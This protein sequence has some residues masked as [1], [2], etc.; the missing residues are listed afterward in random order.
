MARKITKAPVW[1]PNDAAIEAVVDARHGDPFAILGMHAHPD[2]PVSVRVF[3]PGAD[4]AK[5][6]DKKT[7]R[8]VATLEKLHPAGFFAGPVPRRRSPFPYL[9]E[10][11][12]AAASWRTED[13]YRFPPILGDLDVHL[14]AEGRH[15]RVYDRLG[16]HPRRMEDVDGVAFAVWAP[17]ASRVS[18]V[19]E[20]NQWDG[21]RHPMRK[22][23]DIGVWE[24]FIPGVEPGATYKYEILGPDGRLQPLK[25][26]PIA[27][28][29]EHPP[30]TAS[31]IV[32]ADTHQ[33]RDD[34]WLAE[35]Q[36]RQGLAAPMSVYEVHLGSWRRKDGNAYLSYADLADQL[37]AYA[38]DI[39]FTHLEL[40]PVSEFPFDGSW[41][42]Q[43][44]GLFAPTS[45][46]GTP[47]DFAEF[48]D[49]CHEAGLGVI[50]D[51][52]PA[53]FPS[54]AH[55]LMRF[56]GTALYEHEDPRLG[57]HKDWN[58]LIYNFGRNE[59]RNFLIANAL[60]WLERFHI[61]ALR[62]D[63]VA[64][65]LYLDYSRNAGEWIP[66]V[67]GGREN[68]EAIGFIRELNTATFG[69]HPGTTTIAEESTSW[70]QVSRPVDGGGLGFGYKWNMGWM[71]DTL[72]YMSH[73]PVHRKHHHHQMTFG[74]HYAYSEN[75]VLPLSHDE[76]VHGKGSLIGKMP[77]DP[78][79][80]FA[81]L[82][83]YFGFMWTHPGKKLLFMG[84]E[85][86]QEREWNHDRSLDWHLLD[87]APHREV[88]SLVR[89]LNRIY[90]EIP[91]LHVKDADP[92][93]FEWV[94]ATDAAN[95]VYAYLRY[96]ND[97]DPPVLV[98]CNFTPVVRE[99]YRLGVPRQGRWVERLNTDAAAYGGSNVGNGGEVMADPT[100]WQ[101]RPA[102]LSLTIP[103]L[104]TVVF[105]H[106]A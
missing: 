6:I 67:H 40:M 37:V 104:A 77:G 23:L 101:G 45:R 31:R 97:G 106:S 52:V 2:S 10:C 53:H 102:S 87:Q 34:A 14:I 36:E 100:P 75:F 68:L 58:T 24:L 95:S 105:E 48:V 51:W 9:V 82:R 64:S 3:S 32:P 69:E 76:V 81:N 54:D 20:F 39:G 38:T 94:E 5:V 66:N 88:Q 47:E 60:F 63:A 86:A 46:F 85:F 50:I 12:N 92:A 15:R 11:A 73:E 26:D 27:F 25:A 59:V 74:I 30:A 84:G 65:M 62:V 44:V 35:R 18:V 99:G 41:G 22:R 93:G 90:R 17:N 70:P 7:G 61:D 43:P 49:R 72:E 98:V 33:W 13:P 29:Q 83:A 57:F 55:G 103:P 8:E 28:A 80:K 1:R 21:R 16:A 78:W 91:A 96:G 56:D 19:G 42:Y 71:H 79:Q 89:D 4:E